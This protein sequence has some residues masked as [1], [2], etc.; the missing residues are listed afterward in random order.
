MEDFKDD[1]EAIMVKAKER[2]DCPQYV[3]DT[4]IN[5]AL[6]LCEYAYQGQGSWRKYIKDRIEFL[7]NEQ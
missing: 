5:Y 2:G 4:L 6:S 1:L 3:V 7:W